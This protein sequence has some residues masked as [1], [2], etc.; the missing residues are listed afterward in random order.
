MD[1]IK[2]KID[3]IVKKIKSDKKFAEKFKKDPVKAVEGIIGIDLPDEAIYKVVD[4][5]KAKL[6][7]DNANDVVNKIKGLFDNK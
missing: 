2:E 5:V 7:V 3:E 1:K 6:T 4:G